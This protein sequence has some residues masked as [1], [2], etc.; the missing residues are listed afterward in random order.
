MRTITEINKQIEGLKNNLLYF[1]KVAFN[2]DNNHDYFNSAIEILTAY[3]KGD[4]SKF[5]N[6]SQ[7]FE[8][9]LIVERY[10]NFTNTNNLYIITDEK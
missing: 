7:N 5:L 9:F 10:L 6:Y 1:D 4:I 2:G 3:K 8:H